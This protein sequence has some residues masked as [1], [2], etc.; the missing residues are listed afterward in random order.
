MDLVSRLEL[1]SYKSI[2]KV[3]LSSSYLLHSQVV[4]N[5]GC[6][7]PTLSVTPNN[8]ILAL[9]LQVNISQIVALLLYLSLIINYLLHTEKCQF[10]ILLTFISMSLPYLLML[11]HVVPTTYSLHSVQMS[12]VAQTATA[13]KTGPRL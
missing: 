4:M 10:V 3:F 8:P 13:T 1:N 5:I 6:I 12:I 2:I 7:I 9:M 11:L